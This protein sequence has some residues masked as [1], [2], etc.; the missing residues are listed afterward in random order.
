M[1]KFVKNFLTKLFSMEK[2]W[3]SGTKIWGCVDLIKNIQ[4]NVNYHNMK[5]LYF[6]FMFLKH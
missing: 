1:Q 6:N 5:E 2:C 3:F 4:E